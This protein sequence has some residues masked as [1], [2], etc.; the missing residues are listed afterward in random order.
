MER[1]VHNVAQGSPEWLAL[2][3][4]Y[5]SASLAAAMLGLSTK[6]KR[7][8]LL[9]ARKTS[10]A[11]EFSE[12]VEKNVF[13]RGHEA[14]AAARPHAEAFIGEDLFPTTMSRG[15]LLASCDGLTADRRIAWEHKQYNQELFESVTLEG[16]PTAEH[17][18]QCQQALIATG[19]E[20]LLFT[21]SDGTPE[22]MA[23]CWIYPDPAWEARLVAGWHQFLADLAEYVPPEIVAPVTAAA[24]ESLPTVSI[25]LDGAVAIIDN[26][27]VFGERLHAFIDRLPERP[28]TDQEFADADQG[29]KVLQQAQDALE[30]AEA[31][32]LAQTSD[33]EKMRRTVATYVE[34]ARTTRLT[35]EDRKSVV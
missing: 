23:H 15:S 2:R 27:S 26:L 21:V 12:W 11:K 34:L 19:A 20:K 16:E 28:S 22:K 32:A 14:E 9:H 1:I 35:L 17:I 13:E 5:N 7:L 18:P 8:E 31:A 4:Q 29:C 6:V 3:T 25:R 30:Q 10:V 33:I 24:V